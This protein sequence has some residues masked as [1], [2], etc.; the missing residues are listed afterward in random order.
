MV[1]ILDYHVT[2]YPT[3][4]LVL[5]LYGYLITTFCSILLTVVCSCFLLFFRFLK[6]HKEEN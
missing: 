5:V 3:T 4:P 2:K 1:D 6:S